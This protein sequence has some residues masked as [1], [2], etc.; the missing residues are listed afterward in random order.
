MESE[1]ATSSTSLQVKPQSLSEDA[2]PQL[3]PVLT[4]A[5][6]SFNEYSLLIVMYF[7]INPTVFFVCF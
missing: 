2:S 1:E 5:N 6:D 3:Q 7:P 4:N